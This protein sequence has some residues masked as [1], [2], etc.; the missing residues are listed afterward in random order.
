MMS[1]ILDMMSI[2]Y[3]LM[4]ACNDVSLMIVETVVVTKGRR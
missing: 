3:R 1:A 2:S 4:S